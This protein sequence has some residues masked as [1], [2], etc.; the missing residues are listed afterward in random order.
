MN[1]ETFQLER[2]NTPTGR[3]LLASDEQGRLRALD[4]EDHE[5]RMLRLLRRQ[6][7]GVAVELREVTRKSA[8]RR[9]L[10]AYFDGELSAIDALTTAT[11]GTAFQRDVWSALRRIPTGKTLSYGALATKIGRPAAVRA[12]GLANG[13]NPIAI[14]VPC[15]RVIG[16]NASLTGYGGG[17]ERKQWLLAHEGAGEM[18]STQLGLP[19]LSAAGAP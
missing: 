17:I 8:P 14:V 11:G 15:H 19:R 2:F 16:A 4:W 10:D 3:M 6:Y 5:E 9:A 1:T 12:V 13:A 7:R 18:R